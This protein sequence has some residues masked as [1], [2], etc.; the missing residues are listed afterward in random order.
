MTHELTKFLIKV[1]DGHFSHV[2]LVKKFTVVSLL[3][4]VT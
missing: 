4:Q 1:T 2:V 3:A